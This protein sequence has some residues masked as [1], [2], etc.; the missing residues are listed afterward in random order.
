[1]SFINCDKRNFRAV[2]T[3]LLFS[4]PLTLIII[5]LSQKKSSGNITQNESEIF[6]QNAGAPGRKK[7]K[8]ITYKK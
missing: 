4:R 6:V 3:K 5:P 8:G 1:M 7:D 2:T